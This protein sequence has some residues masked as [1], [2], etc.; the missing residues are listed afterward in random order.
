MPEDA[1]VFYAASRYMGIRAKTTAQTQAFLYCRDIR[2][3]AGIFAGIVA[4]AKGMCEVSAV[5][6]RREAGNKTAFFRRQ[7]ELSRPVP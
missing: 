5:G 1:Q 7:T 4:R 6:R 2:S 3:K